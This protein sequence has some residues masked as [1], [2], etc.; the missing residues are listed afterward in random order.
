MG[1]CQSHGSRVT[2]YVDLAKVIHRSEG[3]N[4]ARLYNAFDFNVFIGCV[5]QRQQSGAECGHRR[6]TALPLQVVGVGPAF[7]PA[8]RWALWRPPLKLVQEK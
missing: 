7:Q 1:S 4:L 2:P 3:V 6:D 5:G 8:K